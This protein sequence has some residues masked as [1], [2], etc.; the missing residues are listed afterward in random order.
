MKEGT[1]EASRQT[2][3][4]RR[5][6]R[7]E[8][9]R[10]CEPS[11]PASAPVRY[12]VLIV[13][14]VRL[15]REA[16]ALSLAGHERIEVVGTVDGVAGVLERG[17]QLRPDVVL[18]DTSM[19][20]GLDVIR[21]LQAAAAGT[22]VVAFAVAQNDRDVLH[23]AEAGI[24]GYVSRDASAEDLVATVESVQRGE[25][26]CS[27]KTAA[28]IF[29]RLAQLSSPYNSAAY[30]SRLT[31]REQ[32]IVE[33]IDQGLSNKEI[34]GRL[35]MQP[36]TVKNHVHHILEKLQARRRGEAAAR[37]RGRQAPAGARRSP[38]AS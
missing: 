1:T 19:P 9:K 2:A 26:I 35:G 10:G 16:L 31:R 32:E 36:A 22:K 30:D 18:V 27:P 23:C 29:H 17:H 21:A 5:A 25:L 11:V 37:F 13:S 7:P 12:R 33:L 38:E 6:V 28:S 14:D 15:Y 3:T 4:G 8:G 24:H 34:A 20:E